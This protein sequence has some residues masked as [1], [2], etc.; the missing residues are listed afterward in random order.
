MKRAQLMASL[1]EIRA[2]IRAAGLR[3]TAP[4]V[5]VL[6]RLQKTSTPV[7]H[8]DLFT[9]LADQG[10]DRA[11]IYRNL[12]DLTE[13]GLLSRTDVG[14]HVWRFELRREGQRGHK[15]EHPHFMCTDC[16]EVSCLPGV[17]VRISPA[18]GVPRALSAKNVS[19]QL[20]GL[21][22]RCAA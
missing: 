4:R 15:N 22:D 21:C 12:I 10:F 11:T 2:K 19:V 3:S 18:P 17:S 13:A 16:G 6:Q 14:D 7:S 8:A 9:E 1:A 20:Q 5:A